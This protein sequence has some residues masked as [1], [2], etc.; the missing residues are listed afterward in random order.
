MLRAESTG[1]VEWRLE[2]LDC[3]VNGSHVTAGLR[4]GR[5]EIAARDTV[6]GET[7]TTWIEVEPW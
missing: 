2:T 6:T 3:R 5:H 4:E 7:A 1:P